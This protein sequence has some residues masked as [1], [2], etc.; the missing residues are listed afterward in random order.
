MEWHFLTT[1]RKI[2]YNCFR[3]ITSAKELICF[4]FMVTVCTTEAKPSHSLCDDGDSTF[5]KAAVAFGTSGGGWLLHGLECGR[6]LAVAIKS[7]GQ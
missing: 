5:K 7:L 6:A 4:L 3:T 1:S 2:Y